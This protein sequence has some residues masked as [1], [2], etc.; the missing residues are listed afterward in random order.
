MTCRRLDLFYKL[1]CCSVRTSYIQVKVRAE[2]RVNID[3]HMHARNLCAASV[4]VCLKCAR[5]VC[6][7]VPCY[8]VICLAAA[9]HYPPPR[10]TKLSI[11]VVNPNPITLEPKEQVKLPDM[12]HLKWVHGDLSREGVEELLKDGKDGTYLVRR[13]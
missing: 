5:C 1:V 11:P 3:V 8:A 9:S 10:P 7:A 12:S 2:V 13:G 4:G 6:A